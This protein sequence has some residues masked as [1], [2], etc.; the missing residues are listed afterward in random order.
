MIFYPSKSSIQYIY[1]QIHSCV[2][3][4]FWLKKPHAFLCGIPSILFTLTKYLP[5]MSS[6]SWYWFGFCHFH[7]SNS[8][9]LIGRSSYVRIGLGLG[10]GAILIADLGLGLDFRMSVGMDAGNILNTFSSFCQHI[11]SYPSTFLCL[12]TFLD[13][14]EAKLDKIDIIQ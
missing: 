7:F 1:F 14:S 13:S 9:M 6:I 5:M 12:A 10:L 2:I 11:F 8:S 4:Y 3:L